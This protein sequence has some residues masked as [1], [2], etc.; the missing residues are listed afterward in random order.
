MSYTPCRTCGEP[1]MGHEGSLCSNTLC[2][3]NAVTTPKED[4][5]DLKARHEL[6]WS[7][8][9]EHPSWSSRRVR[10]AAE[11]AAGHRSTTG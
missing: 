1:L 4:V 6:E 2:P 3:T 5:R 8:R 7:L 10:R 9:S 11:R